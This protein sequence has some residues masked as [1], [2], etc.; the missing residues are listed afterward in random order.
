MKNIIILLLFLLFLITTPFAQ[1]YNYTSGYNASGV[2]LTGSF[3]SLDSTGATSYTMVFPL[4]DIYPFDFNQ[5][6]YDSVTAL[7]GSANSNYGTWWYHIDTDAAT[8]SINFDIDVYTGVYGTESQMIAGIKWD[9]A[10]TK[11]TDL[12]DD[13]DLTG[14]ILI[15]TETG[16]L[17]P[18]HVIKI[19][20]DVDPTVAEV[21]AGLDVYYEFVYPAIYQVAK[22]R[23]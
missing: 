14:G 17:H 22:E 7:G 16:K 5:A 12:V 8:D 1:Q 11:V 19:V 4:D 3:T 23:K 13:G 6:V 21:S 9:A 20:I 18:P 15:Y 10:V 2:E